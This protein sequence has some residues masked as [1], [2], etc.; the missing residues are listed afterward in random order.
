MRR[1]KP[2]PEGYLHAA[3]A[4]GH[5]PAACV[6]LEDTPAGIAAGRAAGMTVLAVRG[7]Y[8]DDRLTE[9]DAVLASLADLRCR[10]VGT[11]ELEIEWGAT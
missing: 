5:S 4:L 1:G 2:D 6:V 9:A 3:A 7:T 8:P 10:S 11:K